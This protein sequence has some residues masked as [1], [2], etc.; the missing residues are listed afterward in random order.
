MDPEAEALHLQDREQLKKYAQDLT[1]VYS[2]EK[3]RRK[4]LEAANDKLRRT[5]DLL[6]ESEDRYRTLFDSA[7]DAI[8]IHDLS[9]RLLEVNQAA[10]EALG[11][12][13]DELRK[14]T[15]KAVEGLK[16]EAGLSRRIGALQNADSLLL[17]AVHLKKDGDEIP[18]E[19]NCRLIRYRNETAILVV[20]RD[21]SERK[22]AEKE[23]ARLQAQLQ[24]A[25]KL[26][27]LGGMAAGI[28]HDL[29]NILYPIL[30]YT[31]LA[32]DEV[33]ES[34]PLSEF[35]TQVLESTRRGRDLVARILAFGR[36]SVE[37]RRPVGVQEEIR[38]VVSLLERVIP[39]GV[40]LKTD[41]SPVS[42]S[43]MAAASEIQQIIMNLCTNAYQA[44]H[45]ASGLL[46]VY[47]AEAALSDV[48]EGPDRTA[49]RWACIM[50][51]DTGPGM[52]R[53]VL[54]RI[55][56][57]YFTTKPK[58][59]GTGLGLS[60]V[61]G[62]VRNLGGC[63]DAVSYPGVGTRFTI[64]LPLSDAPA[65]DQSPQP[66]ER[67]PRGTEHVLVVD[68]EPPIV[69]LLTQTLR[70]IGY[71]VTGRTD[72][73]EALELFRSDPHGFDLAILDQAM[74][75]LS[76]PE[77]ARAMH[78]IRPDLPIVACSGHKE[79]ITPE[80]AKAAG[81]RD[82]LL[83]PVDRVVLANRIRQILDQNRRTILV[84]DDEKPIRT[85]LRLTLERAG[86]EVV[87]ARNGAEGM[88]LYRLH[89]PDLV[90]TDMLMGKKGGIDMI[91]ELASDFPDA[92]IIAVT[93]GGAY[94]TESLLE[95]AR[96]LGAL[97]TFS[98]PLP[99]KALLR[100]VREILS[101]ARPW[102]KTPG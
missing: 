33:P 82:H 56:D 37:D 74:P 57:P 19:A 13:R 80:E 78:G 20:A 32:M 43:I 1:A 15:M 66:A 71:T 18:V 3:K 84:V 65:D 21:I 96:D 93:G 89:T 26:E 29:N 22:A 12:D 58:D 91:Y 23:A 75:G 17:E 81:V 2:I 36:E 90:I 49:A 68:D 9:G 35:L 83:K 34:G 39:P 4:D 7:G 87:E 67:S 53:E 62:I 52:N 94:G 24:H 6:R 11:Y 45:G 31:E 27:S 100:A 47:L 14:M 59:Q 50:V 48:P 97:R 70:R 46:E 85:L 98:K 5:T 76:G 86:Y 16:T 41:L 88:H 72:S 73:A 38:Q 77:L 61:Y 44:M 79:A 55:Y 99:Q 95:A 8:F 28:A 63:I 40:E 60:T 42:G 69:K 51:A 30:G 25:R 101:A 54:E 102:V 92:R 10:C 64:H